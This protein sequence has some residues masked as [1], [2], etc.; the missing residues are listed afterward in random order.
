VQNE[1]YFSVSGYDEYDVAQLDRKCTVG[2]RQSESQ[3]GTSDSEFVCLYGIEEEWDV[4]YD[5]DLE[6]HLKEALGEEPSDLAHW[7]LKIESPQERKGR[8]SKTADSQGS[9]RKRQTATPSPNKSRPRLLSPAK[10]SIARTKHRVLESHENQ[11]FESDDESSSDNESGSE[12]NFSGNSDDGED[13]DDGSNTTPEVESDLEEEGDAEAEPDCSDDEL[14]PGSPKKRSAPRSQFQTPRKKRR[15]LAFPTPHSKARLKKKPSIKFRPLSQ[16][17]GDEPTLPEV[18][19]DRILQT[20]HVGA[21]PNALP[22]RETEYEDVLGAVLSLLEDTSGGCVC[23]YS[24]CHIDEGL[25]IL[26]YLWCT[27]YRKD[28]NRLRSRE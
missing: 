8:A 15:T 14:P 25:M 23:K 16:L 5:F 6:D 12:A 1:I 19:R 10:R 27:R 17:A 26:R 21:R 28:G 2:G 18:P 13:S 22:C 24:C 11:D 3:S 4:Y 20:L 9:P 7:N